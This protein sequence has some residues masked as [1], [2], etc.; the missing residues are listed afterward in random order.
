MTN[1]GNKTSLYRVQVL[2]RALAILEAL[3][4]AGESA[5]LAEIAAIVKVHKSTVHRL[6]MSLE[7]HR[8][9]DR[10]PQTG[11]YRLGLRLFDLGNIAVS[12][13]HLRDR[14]RPHLEKLMYNADET[15]HLCVLDNGEVLYIDKVE[16]DRSI[17]MSSTI[18]RRNPVHCTAVGKAL[19]A[20]LPEAEVDGIISQHGMRRC[21]ANTL[22]TPAE[23][24][25][26]L[27]LIL[28]R[29]YAVD[30]EENEEGVRCV[31]AVVRDHSGHA[32]VAI[33]VSAPSFRLP[34]EKVPVMAAL[35]R[36][37]AEAV[38]REWG[39]HPEA[40][41]ESSAETR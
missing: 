21:T 17:R 2:D 15:V 18:G 8:L 41:C 3:A 31:S 36:E 24:K 4:Q 26:E 35:V 28:Q 38:S 39:Y 10:D 6:I 19:L 16:P 1:D 34:T 5:S 9:I 7:G 22:T 37:A 33:S 30:N 13:F 25:A 40:E 23:L 27:K 14:A 29:G 20:S 11:H 12:R 32:A